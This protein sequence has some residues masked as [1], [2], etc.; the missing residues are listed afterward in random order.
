MEPGDFSFSLESVIR[1]HHIYKTV[2]T[3]FTE[4]ILTLAIEEGNENDPF[5]VAV[6]CC[7]PYT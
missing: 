2:W 7:W 1:G 3:P 4:E 5:A 6:I